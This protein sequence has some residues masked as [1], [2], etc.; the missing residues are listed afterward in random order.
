MDFE[1][2]AFKPIVKRALEDALA[3]KYTSTEAIAQL[4][5][6][7]LQVA[8]DL[9]NSAVLINTPNPQAQVKTGWL[10][11]APS[12]L[13]AAGLATPPTIQTADGA[14][15]SLDL[16]QRYSAASQSAVKAPDPYSNTEIL[17]YLRRSTP[18]Q[19]TVQIDGVG[20]L[21]LE[22]NIEQAPMGMNFVRLSYRIPGQAATSDGAQFP[23]VQISGEE[24]PL[25][26]KR[27][28]K[29]IENA[30]RMIY[31]ARQRT[32]MPRS[33]APIASLGDLSGCP[34]TEAGDATD[35]DLRQWGARASDQFAAK[36]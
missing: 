11:A 35:E 12:Q 27:Y 18:A 29:E 23:I 24:M 25:D 13:E 8:A 32:V 34:H 14:V 26:A 2:L 28:L 6:D 17:E 36:R 33:P 4:I 7:R 15:R 9:M 31:S 3:R 1:A 5:L 19:L 21:D 20:G 30:A 16:T 22:R 10:L